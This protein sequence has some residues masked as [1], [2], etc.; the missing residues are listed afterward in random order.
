MY[1]LGA[2]LIMTTRRGPIGVSTTFRLSLSGR[3]RIR[4]LLNENSS[5]HE[6]CLAILEEREHSIPKGRKFVAHLN[7]LQSYE[8]LI[9]DSPSALDSL[10]TVMGF[11][12]EEDI[13]SLKPDITIDSLK[14]TLL[15]QNPPPEEEESSDFV[16]PPVVSGSRALEAAFPIVSF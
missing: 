11:L 3:E 9:N 4:V 5:L 6:I 15:A 12:T 10:V 16:A 14:S 7:K 1:L 2:S 8:D 13:G